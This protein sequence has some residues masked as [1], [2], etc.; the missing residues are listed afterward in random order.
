MLIW[1]SHPAEQAVFAAT[2]LGGG[3]PASSRQVAGNRGVF[4]RRDRRKDG[5]LPE[6][7]RLRRDR[8][9]PCRPDTDL[10]GDRQPDQRGAGGCGNVPSAYVTG[11]GIFGVP[12]GTD[13][14]SGGRVRARGRPAHRDVEREGADYP[15]RRGHGHRQT[16]ERV[17]GRSAAGRR[18]ERSSSTCSTSTQKARP[19]RRLTVTPSLGGTVAHN[20]ALACAFG[21]KLRINHVGCPTC[22]QYRSGK[23]PPMSRKLLATL[24]LV[25]AATFA[26]PAGRQRQST[27]PPEAAAPSA[28]PRVAGR[29]DS[30]PHLRRR[31]PSAPPRASATSSPGRTAPTRTSPPSRPPSARPTSSRRQRRRKRRPASSPCRVPR[32]ART[33]SPAQ[34]PDQ[35]RGVDGDRDRR[36]GGRPGLQRPPS[37]STARGSGLADTGSVDQH[38]AHRVGHRDWRSRDHRRRSS[39]QLAAVA[40]RCY[41]TARGD[42]RRLRDRARCRPGNRG[43]RDHRCARW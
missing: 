12:P 3:L 43:V 13:P 29:R 5:L 11:S 35:P 17:H 42:S 10:T 37:T 36:P 16:G 27:T 24:L 34:G 9:L 28:R 22:P 7:D 20:V 39:S 30:H 38:L 23:A 31:E 25:V 2:T 1:S 21:R 41:G 15:T 6:V 4:Q 18:A 26:A 8:G 40:N 33:R 32:A 19:M 14:H